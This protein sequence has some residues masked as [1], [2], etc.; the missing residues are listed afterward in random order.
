MENEAAKAIR[1]GDVA[2]L[3]LFHSQNPA[4]ERARIDGQ[5]TLLHVAPTGPAIS[6]TS[7]RQSWR[8]LIAERI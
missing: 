8:W 5:R 7:S 4:A 3:N 1:S 6:Q 2:A